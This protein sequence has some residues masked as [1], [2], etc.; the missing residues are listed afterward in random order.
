MP[1]HSLESRPMRL[2]SFSFLDDS[3][4]LLAKQ[5]VTEP[6]PLGSTFLRPGF[7]YFIPSR[8]EMFSA[9]HVCDT[10]MEQPVT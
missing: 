4:H 1:K 9:K 2:D 3:I 10:W 8:E 6:C 5:Q 7:S